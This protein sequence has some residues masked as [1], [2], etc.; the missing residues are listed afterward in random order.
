MMESLKPVDTQGIHYEKYDCRCPYVLELQRLFV[1]HQR[2]FWL[3]FVLLMM[4]AEI[5]GTLMAAAATASDV[6]LGK[7]I[8]DGDSKFVFECNQQTIPGMWPPFTLTEPL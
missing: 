1:T 7:R 6:R 2:F 4:K 5:L 3:T 8:F